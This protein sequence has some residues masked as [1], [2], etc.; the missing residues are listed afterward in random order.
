M[1][2]AGLVKRL[3]VTNAKPVIGVSGGLDS[4]LALLVSAEAVRQALQQ[5]VRQEARQQLLQE[6][7]FYILTKSHSCL[8]ALRSLCRH[9]Y[10]SDEF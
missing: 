8:F 3:T 4:T 1:Q 2:V 6:S 9:S 5:Q 10:V 7:T